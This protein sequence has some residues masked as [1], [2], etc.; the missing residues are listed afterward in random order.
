MRAFAAPSAAP[1]LATSAATTESGPACGVARASRPM[2]VAPAPSTRATA[3][4]M[5]VPPRSKPR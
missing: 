1:A 3:V 4:R 5:L 2:S